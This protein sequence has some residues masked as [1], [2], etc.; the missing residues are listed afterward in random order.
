MQH[1]SCRN[2]E[3]KKSLFRLSRKNLVNILMLFL[4][5]FFLK[6]QMLFYIVEFISS[7]QSLSHVPLFATPWAAA[8]QASLSITNSRSL[9]KL[10]AFALVM[11]SNHLIF[12][13]SLFLLP[14]IF[15]SIRVFSVSQFFASGGQSIGVSALASVLPMNI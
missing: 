12:C 9:L 1:W 10:M 6:S 7:V 11:P 5:A 15:P 8:C 13:R 4:L 2:E 14:S 3:G